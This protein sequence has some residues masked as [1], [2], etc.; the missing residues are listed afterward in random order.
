MKQITVN[1]GS[2]EL[3]VNVI[4]DYY[5]EGSFSPDAPSD[6][7]YYGYRETEFEV[8]KIVTH[9]DDG[10]SAVMDEI[11][12]EQYVDRFI[13]EIELFVQDTLDELAADEAA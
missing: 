4:S 9:A 7:D 13:Y 10:S 8:V 5:V 6:F 11:S 2:L 12:H 3:L 1:I